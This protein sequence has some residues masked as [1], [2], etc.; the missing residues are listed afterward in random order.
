LSEKEKRPISLNNATTHEKGVWAE[1]KN[2]IGCKNIPHHQKGVAAERKN[3]KAIEWRVAQIEPPNKFQ[4][5]SV[6]EKIEALTQQKLYKQPTT[7]T[8]IRPHQA[9]GAI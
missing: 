2:R 9:I 7:P 8:K 3:S 5:P 4:Q 1:E 6:R